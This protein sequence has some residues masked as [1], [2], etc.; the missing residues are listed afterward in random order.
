M[1]T[2]NDGGQQ[3]PMPDVLPVKIAYGQDR[4]GR[5]RRGRKPVRNL[6]GVAAFNN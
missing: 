6:H 1:S 2:L 5:Q 4:M 3:F